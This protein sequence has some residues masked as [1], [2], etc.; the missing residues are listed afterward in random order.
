MG[1]SKSLFNDRTTVSVGTGIPVEGSK[2][3]SSGL[4]GNVSIDYKITRDGR[5]RLRIYRRNDNQS[6]VDG[7]VLET[8]VGFTLVMDFN[9]FKEIFQKAGVTGDTEIKLR[10]RLHNQQ[11]KRQHQLILIVFTGLIL[12]SCNNLKKLPAGE[13]LYT[14][15]TIVFDD[16]IKNKKTV[17]AELEKLLR[18]VP[19]SKTLGMRIRLS[20]YNLGSHPKGRA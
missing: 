17:R 4:T 12:C 6:I 16:T 20:L 14:G 9:Q 18:P 8:G 3:N 2:E 1:V 10:D 11:N 19:N 13:R 15:A 7:E 5:Y